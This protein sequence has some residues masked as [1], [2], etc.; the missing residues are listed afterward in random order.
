MV[1]T[2]PILDICQNFKRVIEGQHSRASGST[3]FAPIMY[4]WAK[5]IKAKTILEIGL[6]AGSTL[7]WLAHAAKE[8]GGQYYGID[9]SV[10]KTGAIIDQTGGFGL[11]I[12]IFTENSIKLNTKWFAQN[13]GKPELVFLDGN[14]Q[15]H[16]IAHEVEQLYSLVPGMGKGYI[17]I[18]DID[19]KSKAGWNSVIKNSKYDFQ[20]LAIPGDAGL[21]ILRKVEI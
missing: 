3:H 9:I 14:H 8:L 17:F 12:N 4:L 19:T 5:V 18:H 16:T 21:G 15:E 1:E 6:G 10:Q 7:Y 11:P 13:V 2:P 20:H